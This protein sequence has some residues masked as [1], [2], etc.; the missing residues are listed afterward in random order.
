[1]TTTPLIGYAPD[2][3]R[4]DEPT[5]SARLKWVVIVDEALP[6]GRAVNSA[7]C[8]AAATSA[9]V[10][11]TVDTSA[12]APFV[13]DTMPTSPMVTNEKGSAVPDQTLATASM[14]TVSDRAGNATTEPSRTSDFVPCAVPSVD[15]T[16]TPESPL[17][18][19]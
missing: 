15:Q 1:M 13:V 17:A 18:T 16:S 4:T 6:A 5:R 3:I 7:V 9:A 12:S 2:E 8:V 11:V 10:T 14:F 19:K